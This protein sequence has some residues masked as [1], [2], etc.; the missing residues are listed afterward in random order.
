[1]GRG[2][3][4]LL[5]SSLDQ[6][7]TG[8]R[9]VEVAAAVSGVHAQV[10]TSAELQLAARVDVVQA[11]VRIPPTSCRSGSRRGA[12][13]P[14]LG[15]QGAPRR[16]EL[17]SGGTGRPLPPPRR[18]RRRG[19]EARRRSGPGPAALGLCLLPRARGADEDEALRDVCRRFLR[20]YGPARLPDFCEWFAASTFSVEDAR[21][22]FEGLGPDLDEVC[23][24]G[25]TA[26]VLAGDLSFPEPTGGS[27]CCRSTT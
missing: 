6:R 2:E 19:R 26:F 3:G 4:R 9:L 7:A 8:G 10:Q 11:E 21:A 20:T 17:P 18:S 25:R 24:E 1:M 23:V 22:L 13:Q 5:R 12:R 27:D 16:F 14:P 15:R